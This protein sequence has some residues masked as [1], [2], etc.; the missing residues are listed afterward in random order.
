MQ[1]IP[2]VTLPEKFQHGLL[3][4]INGRHI[5]IFSGGAKTDNATLLDGVR[6]IRAGGGFG[7]IIDRNSF[8][9][10]RLAALGLLDQMIRMYK[11][12]TP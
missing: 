8:Q 9:R 5:V 12:E 11:G 1:P 10:D 4:M 6:A 3:S 7:S 2:R